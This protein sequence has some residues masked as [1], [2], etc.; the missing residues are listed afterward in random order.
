MIRN[1]LCR[2]RHASGTL[3]CLGGVLTLCASLPL[4][5]PSAGALSRLLALLAGCCCAMF[6]LAFAIPSRC[7][8]A[9]RLLAVIVALGGI[10]AT[11]LL[12]DGLASSFSALI[13][14]VFVYIG[15]TFRPGTSLLL[16]PWAAVCW[17][18]T[19]APLDDTT[20]ARL[21]A[22]LGI[23][24]VVGELLSR[25]SAEAAT[26][27]AALAAEAEV[28]PLTG[29][30]NRQGFT[31]RLHALTDQDAVVFVDLDHFKKVNDVFGHATGDAVLRDLGRVVLS[32]LR[33]KD[34]AIRYG[35]E[36]IVLLL[37][38]AGAAGAER[39]LTRLKAGW[40]ASHPELTFS[41]GIAVVG[42]VDGPGA[43]LLADRALYQAKAAGRARWVHA[44]TMPAQRIHGRLTAVPN[45]PPSAPGPGKDPRRQLA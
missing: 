39:A 43:V 12:T 41:A 7:A 3:V 15:L 29:L 14:L 25:K 24:A 23:W 18:V 45:N 42:E 38:G 1:A 40:A 10:G 2:A 13:V 9:G 19:N 28:D 36:E 6:L 26:M 33:P 35:G 20:L 11:G 37:P 44:G 22:V 30:L 16:L 21:P 4:L 8:A 32:V 5:H 34:T 17:A 27:R 31:E